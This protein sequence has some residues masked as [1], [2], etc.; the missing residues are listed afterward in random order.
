MLA[1]DPHVDPRRWTE[2]PINPL[3]EVLEKCQILVLLTDHRAFKSIP[4]RVLQ[5]KVVVDT[6]G[7]WR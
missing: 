7:I 5:Q 1:Y 2:M 6:R 4:R 3:A